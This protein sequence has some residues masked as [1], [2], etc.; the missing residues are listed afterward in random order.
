MAENGGAWTSVLRSIRESVRTLENQAKQQK[1]LEGVTCFILG[2]KY[3]SEFEVFLKPYINETEKETYTLFITRRCSCLAYIFKRILEERKGAKIKLGKNHLLTNSALINLAAV[4]ASRLAELGD[5][6]ELPD[7]YLIDDSISYGRAVTNIADLF[8]HRLSSVLKKLGQDQPEK[9][10]RAYVKNHVKIRVYAKKDQ[11]D[12]LSTEYRELTKAERTI[13]QC[14]WNDI[15][16]RVSE[17]INNADVAN[18]AFVFSAGVDQIPSA[19]DETW[20]TIETNYYQH[21]QVTFMRAIPDE[22]SPKAVCAVRCFPCS[23]GVKYRIVPFLFFPKLRVD[24]LAKMEDVIFERLGNAA[25]KAT[26]DGRTI[27]PFADKLARYRA[28]TTR[29]S[30]AEFV[31]MYL[32]QSLLLA[33]T[34]KH[35]AEQMELH[36]YDCEKV[37]WTYSYFDSELT[38][39]NDFF[40]EQ[41]LNDPSLWLPEEEVYRTISEAV[42]RTAFTDIAY[43]GEQI[44]FRA[45]GVPGKA[46]EEK[47]LAV[48]QCPDILAN[49]FEDLLFARAI[50]SEQKAHDMAA[51]RYFLLDSQRFKGEPDRRY[52]LG[53][54]EKDLYQQTGRERSA[55]ALRQFGLTDLL[56]MTFQM[57]DTGLMSIVTRDIAD[58]VYGGDGEYHVLEQQVRVCEQALCAYPRRY[59]PYMKDMEELVKRYDWTEVE[60]YKL[61]LRYQV[62]PKL[63]KL[64]NAGDTGE[65]DDLIQQLKDFLF[66]FKVASQ[67]MENWDAGVVRRFAVKTA[68]DEPAGQPIPKGVKLISGTE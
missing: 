55:D 9:R 23:V 62:E 1:L 64:L 37:N 38:E 52:E 45:G 51:K 46:E 61:V 68:E 35:C 66:A 48:R 40:S 8:L 12:L 13:P 7:I 15:S 39:W 49:Q 17:L 4:I 43:Q 56:A 3:F 59:Q 24:E 21:R 53:E 57:M 31:T 30:R 28:V 22:A 14:E 18:A 29:R 5:E 67:K 2:G 20:R 16:T 44:P 36:D 42:N 33:F 6:A 58:D 41:R 54:F 65:Y 10:S 32:S 47:A 60:T 11:Y 63:R 27:K 50:E 26:E 19:V 25:E 34:Q